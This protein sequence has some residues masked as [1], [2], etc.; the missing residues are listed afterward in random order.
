M[1]ALIRC[2]VN[3]SGVSVP[4]GATVLDAIR[5]SDPELARRVVAGEGLVSDGRGLPLPPGNAVGPGDIIRAVVSARRG[6]RTAEFDA[7]P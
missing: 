5:A 6:G 4:I 3:D 2:F 1:G 7:L